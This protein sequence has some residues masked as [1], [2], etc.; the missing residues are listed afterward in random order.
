MT[1]TLTDRF[2]TELKR[3]STALLAAQK[4]EERFKDMRYDP[5]AKDINSEYKTVST[6]VNCVGIVASLVVLKKRTSK[7]LGCAITLGFSS[8]YIWPYYHANIMETLAQRPNDYGQAIRAVFIFKFP[9]GAHTKEYER[10]SDDFRL[11]GQRKI[12][13][14]IKQSSSN[15]RKE[16]KSPDH[17]F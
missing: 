3:Q 13:E 16:I 11:Y 5:T 9:E 12:A 15:S 1:G 2:W 14:K 6:I 10:L 17:D 8:L 7:A 4:L